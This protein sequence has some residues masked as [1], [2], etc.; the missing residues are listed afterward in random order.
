[1]KEWRR[2]KKKWLG[3]AISFLWLFSMA[4]VGFFVPHF[5][6]NIPFFKVKALY[7]EGLETIPPDVVAEEVKN[8]KNNW[9]FINSDILL[10]NLNSATGNS[11][12]DLKVRRIFSK[13]GV[14]LEIK[15]KERKPIFTV[16]EDGTVTFFDEMGIQFWSPYMDT[17]NPVVYTHDIDMIEKNFESMKNII[18]KINLDLNEIYVTNLG[19]IIYT[20]EGLRLTL[21]PLFFLSKN[22]VENVARLQI[23]YNIIDVKEMEINTEG[24]VI[25]RGEKRR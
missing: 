12:S 16:I 14:E 7:I 11:I 20:K 4:L 21:P 10:R 6:D 18:H 13:G 8:L 5:T 1:M 23:N 2:E 17:V 25:I 24:L 22:L 9:L 3:Y 15:I 19:T